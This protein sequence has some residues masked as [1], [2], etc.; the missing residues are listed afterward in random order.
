MLAYGVVC[1]IS[2][3]RTAVANKQLANSV[4]Q[5]ADGLGDLDWKSIVK[6]GE[7]RYEHLMKHSVPNLNKVNHTVFSANPISMT[8]QAWRMCG[9]VIPIVEGNNFVYNIL[10]INA[11]IAGENAIR[12]ITIANTNILVSAYPVFI[13]I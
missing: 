1:T 2:A 13:P 5:P 12:I 3:I 4:I 9:G 6:K 11:G 7:T 10:Y 8:N